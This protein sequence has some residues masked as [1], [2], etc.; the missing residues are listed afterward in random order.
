MATYR[1]R[2]LTPL[3][4]VTVLTGFLAGGRSAAVATGDG[5]RWPM[6]RETNESRVLH[7]ISR[8]DLHAAMSELARRHSVR[9]ARRGRLFHTSNP[10]AYYLDGVRWS[11]WGENVGYTTGTVEGLQR[12]FMKSPPHRANILNRRFKRVAIGTV[13]R[14]GTLWVTVFFYG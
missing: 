4:A 10:P 3:V 11:T 6:K 8:V 12:L 14:D 5:D 9:M 13:R 1:S 2:Y 7:D